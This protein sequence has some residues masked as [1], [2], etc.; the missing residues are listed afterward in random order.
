MSDERGWFAT[1]LRALLARVAQR[2]D[3]RDPDA[4]SRTQKGAELGAELGAENG[5]SNVDWIIL[6]LG[7][8]GEKYE[9]SRHNV[10]RDAVSLLA[11]R[12]GIAL[13]TIKHGARFG[14]G[15]LA[16]SRVALALTTVYMNESGRPAASLARFYKVPPEQLL[17][18][19]D[20]MDLALGTIRLREGGGTAGH[21]GLSDIVR[22]LGTR[23]FPRLRMGVDRP[24][25]GWDKTGWVLGRFDRVQEPV[26]RAMVGE[27]AD[28]VRAVVENG[29][30]LAMN[31]HHR[32]G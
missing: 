4:P 21:N 31:E 23:E 17:I 2:S 19:Y 10:G 16:G 13:G 8:P 22:Q 30:R 26:A 11:E 27:S 1:R 32:R 18:V 15:R 14:L 12:E 20:E 9:G 25:P 6:G 29:V 3:R 5:A 7:N 28:I 24:P